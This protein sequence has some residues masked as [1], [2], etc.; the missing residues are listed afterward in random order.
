MSVPEAKDW[1]TM[2][3][4][5]DDLYFE[6]FDRFVKHVVG[7]TIFK[8]ASPNTYLSRF[9][10]IGD[11]AFAHL[12]IENCESRWLDMLQN[13]S[14]KS[15]ENCKYTD[16]GISV[17]LGRNRILKGWSPVGLNRYNTLFAQVRDDRKLPDQPF[18]SY[19]M[20]HRE[21]HHAI[22]AAKGRRAKRDYAE[23]QGVT[24]TH[25]M[26]EM[27]DFQ[28]AVTPPNQQETSTNN[29]QVVGLYP[30]TATAV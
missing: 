16:G 29:P 21:D 27:S 22:S 11:E 26:D 13:N 3:T 23:D 2:R 6:F 17:R 25:V 20:K 9:V 5:Q 8:S 24:C 19:Y 12:V 14:T 28:V 15:K 18:E 30:L 4:N 7:V 10:K 1:L